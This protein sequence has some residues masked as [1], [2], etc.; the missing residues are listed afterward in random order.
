MC[1]P[2]TNSV[3][4]TTWLTAMAAPVLA[5]VRPVFPT[6]WEGACHPLVAMVF[7][8]LREKA[9]MMEI[10]FPM[11]VA[12]PPVAAKGVFQMERVAA[13]HPLVA[14]E[15]TLPVISNN[16]MITTQSMEMD[17]LRRA[18]VKLGCQMEQVVAVRRSVAT[19]SM[20]I[21]QSNVTTPILSMAMVAPRLVFV[22]LASLTAWE[23]ADC[24]SV[25]MDYSIQ[26]LSSVTTETPL[27]M[28][29]V[30]QLAD[31]R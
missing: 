21:I 6:G 1:L 9:A 18:S 30:Q 28:T 25:G 23:G 13:S 29:A 5:D 22:K 2:T 26:C 27:P 20:I 14:T 31:V 12:Q 7:S 15:F 4:I 17:V 10:R 24:L 3:T 19:D 11:M 16:V 8:T